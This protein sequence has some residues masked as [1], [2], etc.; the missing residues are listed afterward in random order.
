M[1]ANSS[2]H[3][4]TNAHITSSSSTSIEPILSSD[5]K[6]VVV[7]GNAGKSGCGVD[8]IVAYHDFNFSST[9]LSLHPITYA[10]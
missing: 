5:A 9:H 10:Q 3:G 8:V 4:A 6:K 1:L 2:I 7:V